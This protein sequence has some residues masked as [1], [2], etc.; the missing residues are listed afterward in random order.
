M[1]KGMILYLKFVKIK[2]LNK[3]P[4]KDKGESILSGLERS[5]DSF[6]EK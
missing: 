1:D 5:I 6:R 2:E 4:L 3:R